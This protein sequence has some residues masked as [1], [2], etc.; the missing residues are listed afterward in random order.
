MCAN[1]IGCVSVSVYL[2]VIL[3][4][5]V[6]AMYRMLHVCVLCESNGLLCDCV[7]RLA[8]ITKI[9]IWV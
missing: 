8:T 1:I 5:F 2:C 7:R 9:G 6:C 3:V 4:Y